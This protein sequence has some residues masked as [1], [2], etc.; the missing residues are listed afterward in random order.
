MRGGLISLIGL[1]GLIIPVLA[2]A[3][4][5]QILV[6]PQ[7]LAQQ[8]YSI[9]GSSYADAGIAV[10]GLNIKVPYSAHY[11]AEL[12]VYGPLFTE[13]EA[14]TGLRG[15]SGH[16]IGTAAVSSRPSAAGSQTTVGLGTAERYQASAH[17]STENIGGGIEWEKARRIDYDANDLERITGS[18][19]VQYLHNDWQYDIVS[20]GRL[21]E[22]GAQGYYGIPETVYAEEQ[23]SDALLLAGAFKGDLE[24]A[25]IRSGVSLREFES[26]YRIPSAAV[27]SEVTSGYGSAMIEGRTLEVQ[28]LAL[29]LRADLEHERVSGDIG[30]HSRTRGSVLILPE[31]R[32]ERLTLKAGLN[33]VFQSR[34][35]A[36]WL[37]QAGLDFHADDNTKIYCAYTEHVAQPDFESLYYADPYR[38]GN[39]DLQLQHARTLE[40]GLHQFLSAELDWRIGAFQRRQEN[41]KDW[42]KSAAGDTAWSAADLGTLD[43]SG[44][45][46]RVNYPASDRLKLQLFYQWVAKDSYDFYAGLYELDYPEHLLVLTGYWQCIPEVQLFGSQ[47]LRRQSAHNVRSGSDFGAE[48]SLGLHYDPRFAKNVRLSFLVENLWGTDFQPIPGLDPRP[49]AVSTGITVNW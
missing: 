41:A 46:A 19:F 18:A 29:N 31:A 2:H 24:S 4:N 38:T 43:V 26:E 44:L 7:G 5:P 10:N 21:K 49:L 35:S 33:S 37:P 16:L 17:S 34:E 1:I 6:T 8:N 48:A 27:A 42:I 22:Y 15:V 9:R 14:C 23:T 30:S 39:A 28:H 25:F 36:E 45:D 12:P 13:A 3:G 11:N 20:A 47:A 40:I 32:F